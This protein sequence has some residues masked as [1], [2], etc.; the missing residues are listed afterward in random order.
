MIT[1]KT[2]FGPHK[3]SDGTLSIRIRITHNRKIGYLSTPYTIFPDALN[4]KGEL[5]NNLEN[6]ELKAALELRIKYYMKR[7]V[8]MGDRIDTIDV[9]T[10]ITELS[11]SSSEQGINL[12]PYFEHK[13]EV[14]SLTRAKGTIVGYHTA[15]NRFKKFLNKDEL[16]PSELTVKLLN[17]FETH[18]RTVLPTFD[19]IK[20]KKTVSNT[21]IRLY[22]AYLGSLFHEAEEEDILK[23]NP[24]R[25]GYHKVKPNVPE[26][27]NLNIEILRKFALD[28]PVG[29]M[30]QTA[31]DVAMISFM[32]CGMNTVDIF[33]CPK[34][35]HNRITYQRS[36][37]KD[38]RDDKAETSVLIQPELK[39][40]LNRHK[41]KE[42]QFDFHTRYSN[43]PQFNKQ[44][45][46]GL[47]MICKRL[48]IPKITTYYFRHT[49]ATIARN[50]LH[51]SKDDIHLALNH[52][53]ASNITDKYIAT[54]WSII[55]RTNRKIIDYLYTID[56]K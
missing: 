9:K 46:K 8:V 20:K 55:D 54:D 53:N 44:I 21:G 50:D 45:N 40:Y 13:I 32:L 16:Y 19:G 29:K 42:L 6:K 38:H 24:F 36:K 35:R 39:V 48:D 12:L 7:V 31:H 27:R 22:F 28:K 18:L 2:V 5:L 34:S 43:Y 41:D 15:L 17:D 25:K 1:F 4:K 10:L 33:K 26:K 56:K 37:T 52:S 47:K 3:R 11:V 14:F 30:Q 49:W 51:I 23:S